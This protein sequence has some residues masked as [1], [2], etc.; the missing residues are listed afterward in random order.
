MEK[1]KEEVRLEQTLL[2][3]YAHEQLVL[4]ETLRVLGFH[5]DDIYA[6]FYNDGEL[7]TTLRSGDKEWHLSIS[8]GKK[9]EIEP[10]VTIYTAECHWWNTTDD[11]ARKQGIF[12]D[13]MPFQRFIRVVQSIRAENI[14][15]PRIPNTVKDEDVAD[16]LTILVTKPKTAVQAAVN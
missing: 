16:L 1:T 7:F 10:Y 2:E 11:E 3:S 5:V 8:R 12:N 4:W 15:I 14:V 13:Y 9:I 6:A